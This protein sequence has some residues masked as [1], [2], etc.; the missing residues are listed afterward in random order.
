[1]DI[2]EHDAD[3]REQ[4]RK[5]RQIVSIWTMFRTSLSQLLDSYN[6]GPNGE[7]H[8]AKMISPSDESIV[9]DCPL[10]AHPEKR[11]VLLAVT[12]RAQVVKGRL[13]IGC[14]IE[15]WTKSVLPTNM[16]TTESRRK[17][18]FN[19]EENGDFLLHGVQQLTVY[20]AAELLLGTAL[21]KRD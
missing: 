8:P 3:E 5:T 18:I 11:F 7:I 20:E 14:E 6:A 9:I 13:Q 15:K 19:L 1:M 17:M 4:E 2:F 21:L 10:G 16:P 12:V